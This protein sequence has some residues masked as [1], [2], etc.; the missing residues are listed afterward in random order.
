MIL[1]M[2]AGG[3]MFGHVLAVSNLTW[4]LIGL[5]ESL[6]VSPMAVVAVILFIY[7]ILGT[8]MSAPIILILTVPILAPLAVA[9][10]I[11]L[12]WFGVVLVMMTNL[13]MI[14][15][16]YGMNVFVL[17]GLVP[18]VPTF[19]IFRGVIPFVIVTLIVEI[20][21]FFYEPL[22]IWLPYLIM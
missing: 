13:G 16:P 3:L 2:V 6:D 21:I 18:D 19:T 20:L 17:R 5:I 1:F 8:I 10:G 14:T 22:A 9:M 12:I 15:P 7:L 11:D 4:G